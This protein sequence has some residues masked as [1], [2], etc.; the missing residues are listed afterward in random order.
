M[1][2]SS[3]LTLYDTT[4]RDGTQGEG[5]SFSVLDKLRIAEKLDAF[6]MHYIEGGWPGSNPKDAAFFDAA[7]QRAF[8]CARLAAFGSTRRANVPVGEDPQIA[9]LLA[10][11]TPVVTIFGKSWRLHVTEVLGIDPAENRA[12]ITDSVRHLK[13]HGREVIYDA[14]HFFDGYKDDPGHALATLAAAREGGADLI[15]LCDTNGGCLPDELETIFRAA[16]AHCAPTSLGIHT[17]NDCGLGV[18]NA[19]AAVRAGAVQVQGTIN[20]YGERTGNCNLTTLVPCLQAKMGVDAVADLSRLSEL[21][22]FVDELANCPHDPRA[23]FVG[24]TAFTHKGGV[25]VHAVQKLARSYEHMDPAVV[26]NRQHIL[27][28]ELSGQSNVLA[29]MRDLGLH[30]TK[31]SAEVAA[32]LAEIKRLEKEG[33]EFEAAEASFRAAGP[34]PARLAPTALR[35]AGIPLQLS[36]H[37]RPAAR[38]LRGHREAA[39]R[40]GERIHRGGRRRTGQRAR[41]RPAQGPAPL[42]SGHR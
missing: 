14:E 10:A 39:D 35:V 9:G 25:H 42:L 2:P 32:V 37:R 31:G 1:S 38:D 6:G 24:S 11:G 36:P 3:R 28:S 5:I 33:Y 18:A 34:P 15:V 4:L 8:R 12:M 17:H 27:V 22:F 29:K 13:R 20:G 23:P 21:S 30:L 16:A 40:Q 41:R 26:G 19:L 7:R